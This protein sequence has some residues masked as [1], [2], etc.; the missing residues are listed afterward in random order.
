VLVNPRASI[1]LSWLSTLSAITLSTAL[2]YRGLL[3][4]VPVAI[5]LYT[6][7]AILPFIAEQRN[8]PG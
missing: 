7:P 8:N 1:I 4:A 3:V 6:L 5:S 2:L